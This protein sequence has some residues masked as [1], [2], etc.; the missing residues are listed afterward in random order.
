MNFDLPLAGGPGQLVRAAGLAG[1]S[2][3]STLR[4]REGYPRDQ[5]GPGVASPAASS[6]IDGSASSTAPECPAGQERWWVPTEGATGSACAHG[7]ANPWPLAGAALWPGPRMEGLTR[8]PNPLTAAT[9]YST[10][11]PGS[12]PAL[13][14]A[15][16]SRTSNTPRWLPLR[17]SAGVARPPGRDSVARR[18]PG[19][20]WVETDI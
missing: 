3:R 17:V 4:W 6:R 8:T 9:A 7:P 14:A 18:S 16:L 5:L 20:C 15:W 10:W 2:A 13:A 12:L 1:C 19:K 11:C